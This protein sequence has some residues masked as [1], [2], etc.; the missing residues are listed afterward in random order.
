MKRSLKARQVCLVALF[1]VCFGNVCLSQP[2]GESLEGFCSKFTADSSRI[3]VALKVDSGKLAVEEW[4]FYPNE[5][6]KR[7]YTPTVTDPKNLAL[8]EK[9]LAS[10]IQNVLDASRPLCELQTPIDPALCKQNGSWTEAKMNF[11]RPPLFKQKILV[12]FDRI[13]DNSPLRLLETENDEPIEISSGRIA[14]KVDDPID[15]ICDENKY[16][17]RV[18][19][20]GTQPIADDKK[21]CAA[22]R[23]LNGQFWNNDT[24]NSIVSEFYASRG[25]IPTLNGANEDGVRSLTILES[26][27]LHRVLLA[28]EGSESENR[29]DVLKIFY[30]LL[31]HKEWTTFDPAASL[32]TD[33]A[34]QRLYE[35]DERKYFNLIDFNYQQLRLGS[36][37]F[38][39]TYIQCFPEESDT[40]FVCLEVSQIKKD[41][42]STDGAIPITNA[43]GIVDPNIVRPEDQIKPLPDGAATRKKRNRAAPD[44]DDDPENLP[45]TAERPQKRAKGYF[46]VG[47]GLNYEFGDRP[48]F[49][50]LF[51]RHRFRGDDFSVQI[52][53]ED[54]AFGNISYFRDYLFFDRLRRRLSLQ[55]TGKSDFQADRRLNGAVTDER[56]TGGLIRVEF[57]LVNNWRRSVFRIFGQGQ[58]IMV[59][60]RGN[61]QPTSK[62]HLNAIDVG[63]FFA[64]GSNPVKRFPQ[65]MR[66]ESKFRF[67]LGLAAHEAKFTSTSFNGKYH[68]Q[69]PKLFEIDVGGRAELRTGNTPQYEQASFGGV[70]SVR[71]FRTDELIGKKLWS[72]QPEVWFP[73]FGTE[74]LGRGP[75]GKL[76]RESIR[77]AGFIDVGGV[78]GTNNGFAGVKAG[79]GL[80]IRFVK[81]PIVL[82]LD[83]AYG[84]GG[85]PSPQRRGKIHF[86]VETNLPF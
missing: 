32:E 18:V 21:I 7:T 11:R 75:M 53:G 52:G 1:L 47:G 66:F 37:G 42:G 35:F 82:K 49:F 12:T 50:G 81:N 58:K 61:G 22:L 24:V 54:E 79:P 13:Q 73:V 48:R 80:G 26:P 51:Q 43:E 83:W 56:R 3:C 77:L 8:L 6:L 33:D 57:D 85:V 44:T 69:L 86:G 62:E 23:R 63:L 34:G 28:I 78:Y 16:I 20:A 9:F 45:P 70:E 74:N 39:L 17:F 76:F 72:I 5:A 27:I 38:G 46:Y 71:G 10:R 55:I 19:E 14:F 2:A 40:E 25:L 84:L 68:R 60:L 36:L 64:M 29:V 15:E 59:T 65:W 41:T 4:K 31:S 67:G 30:N